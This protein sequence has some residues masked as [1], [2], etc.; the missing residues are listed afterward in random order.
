[1]F[2]GPPGN[3]FSILTNDVFTSSFVYLCYNMCIF[4]HCVYKKSAKIIN[5]FKIRTN[6]K[7]PNP[8]PRKGQTGIGFFWVT[9]PLPHDSFGSHLNS[10]VITVDDELELQNFKQA[11]VKFA[12]VWTDHVIDNHPVMAVASFDLGKGHVC[13]SQ[14]MLQIVIRKCSDRRC[15]TLE[16]SNISQVLGKFVTGKGTKSRELTLTV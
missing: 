3:L 1:M 8:Y 6:P 11:A 15:C 4:S 5:F 13:T 9:P 12:D 2:S 14:Y 16:I 7:K 10:K